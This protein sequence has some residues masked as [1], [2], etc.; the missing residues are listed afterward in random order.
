MCTRPRVYWNKGLSAYVFGD[1]GVCQECRNKDKRQ[2]T[3]KAMHELYY[4]QFKN[5]GSRGCFLTLTYDSEHLP[6]DLSLHKEHI[7]L[8][9]HYLRRELTLR[10]M[11]AKKV[12]VGFTP[13]GK[14]SYRTIRR[15]FPLRYM[16][17]GE[18]GE[19]KNEPQLYL[20][21]V[22]RPHYHAVIFN[23][24]PEDEKD[25]LFEIPG[26]K[27]IKRSKIIESI[28][29][30]GLS[31]V[32]ECNSKT[33]RYV[34][35]YVQKKKKGK[36]KIFYEERDLVPE[37]CNRSLGLGSGYLKIAGDQIKKLGYVPFNGFKCPIPRSYEQRLYVTEEEKERRRNDK[38]EYIR[39]A[40]ETFEEN[41]DW[42]QYAEFCDKHKKLTGRIIKRR[43]WIGYKSLEAKAEREKRL[44][45][46]A[47]KS[48]KRK[49]LK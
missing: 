1:C 27:N 14:P 29:D 5:N 37:F 13:K 47:E 9:F 44:K 22:G 36:G 46:K 3:M 6:K 15:P 24:S 45:S 7:D 19:A 16:N 26:E 20:K 49:E 43:D 42:N 8:F 21:E 38:L 41:I 11:P 30:K 18:Y 35:S 2:N 25:D 40:N 33:C 31:S 4:Q 17:C 39:K 48:L 23:W 28:W 12:F 32:G 10:H 34:A